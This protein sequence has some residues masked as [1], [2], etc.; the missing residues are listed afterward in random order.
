MCIKLIMA[1]TT[2][3]CDYVSEKDGPLHPQMA[4]FKKTE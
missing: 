3:H 4:E 1:V 2:I